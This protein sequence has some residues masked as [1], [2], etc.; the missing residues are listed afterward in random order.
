MGFWSGAFGWYLPN[1]FDGITHIRFRLSEPS[2]VRLEVYDAL[3]SKVATLLEGFYPA[4]EYT[5]P[6][7]GTDAEGMAVPSG[8]YYYRIVAG[9]VTL[10]QPMVLVR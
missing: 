2:A 10:V 5:V 3:G 4:S 1:P 8:M 6:W 9:G 7:H